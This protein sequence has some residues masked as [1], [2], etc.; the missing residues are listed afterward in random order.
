MARATV[1]GRPL[2]ARQLFLISHC[3]VCDINP[4]RVYSAILIPLGCNEE[5]GIILLC[6][7]VLPSQAVAAAS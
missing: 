3:L 1:C 2:L 7:K 4:L 5:T 6:I